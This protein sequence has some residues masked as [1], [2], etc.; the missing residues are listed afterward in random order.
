[1]DIGKDISIWQ[2]HDI[3][4][5]WHMARR[6]RYACNLVQHVITR[7]AV[8]ATFEPEACSTSCLAVM[9]QNPIAGV[10]E[11]LIGSGIWAVEHDRIM[12]GWP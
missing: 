3:T 5:L 1:L 11:T 9:L 7:A 2:A 4:D 10:I 8:Q 12:D 6:W